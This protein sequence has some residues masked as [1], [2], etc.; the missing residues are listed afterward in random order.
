MILKN[1]FSLKMARRK[2]SDDDRFTF[3]A[4]DSISSLC[5]SPANRA[6]LLVGSWSASTTLYDAVAGAKLQEFQHKAAVLDCAMDAST[7]FAGGVDCS[8]TAHDVETGVARVVGKHAAG[9]KCVEVS[10]A[11]NS[12]VSAGWDAQLKVWDMRA[13]T[14]G[15]SGDGSA[16]ASASATLPAKA[17]TMAT[18]GFSAVVGC[19]QRCVNVY[20]LRNLDAPL[21][22]R[23]SPLKK[24][25]RCVRYYPDGSAFCLASVE[26]RVAIEYLGLTGDAAAEKN[27]T[28]KCH[29]SK[30]P[31]GSDLVFPVNALAFHPIHHS[32]ATGGCDGKVHVW[33]GIRRKRIHTLPTFDTSIA[34][35]DFNVDGTLLA[36]AVS[37]TFESGEKADAPPDSVVVRNISEA[38]VLKKAKAK[39]KQRS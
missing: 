29:R 34:A 4:S 32:F 14:T 27:F 15:S 11:T 1:H 2:Q 28:F 37:Y 26:G 20:D 5:F 19:A 36:V 18:H 23:T 25:S 12:I 31:E 16:A 35:L 38:H 10:A 13:A 30:T 39:K 21:E 33:D 8:I 3:A 7:C 6:H 9:V 17:F 22:Q 24:Q